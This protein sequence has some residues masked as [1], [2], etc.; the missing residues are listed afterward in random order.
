MTIDQ[1]VGVKNKREIQFIRDDVT[2]R[3]DISVSKSDSMLILAP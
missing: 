2:G 3:Y 1:D